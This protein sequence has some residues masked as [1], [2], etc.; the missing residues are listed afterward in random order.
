MSSI[1]LF[2]RI[3]H[4][5]MKTPSCTHFRQGDVL[6]ER[7][8]EIPATA[9]KQPKATRI[10]LAHGEVTGHHHTLEVAY[11]ADWWKEGEISPTNEK[12]TTLAG[13]L[14]VSLPA[15]GVVKHPEHA[16]TGHHFS[17]TCHWIS[18]SGW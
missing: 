11:P 5:K 7:I 12:P 16:E 4:H 1:L 10:I 8:A 2:D 14:F 9:E 17:A 13:E 15:G 18:T 3:I 6:I